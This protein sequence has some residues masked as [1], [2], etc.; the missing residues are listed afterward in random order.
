MVFYTLECAAK[1]FLPN[2]CAVITKRLR[3]TELEC[4]NILEKIHSFKLK[5]NLSIVVVVLPVSIFAKQIQNEIC[6]FFYLIGSHQTVNPHGS[7]KDKD[8][9]F[10]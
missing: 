2:T 6:V 3:N 9:H 4:K 1:T 5:V 7:K 8:L 10:F